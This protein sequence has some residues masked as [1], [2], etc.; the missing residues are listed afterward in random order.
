M[1]TTEAG[2]TRDISVY[3]RLIVTHYIIRKVLKIYNLLLYCLV[4]GVRQLAIDDFTGTSTATSEGEIRVQRGS[5][6]VSNEDFSRPITVEAEMKT[7]GSSECIT[8]SLFATSNYKNAD[9]SM[10][11]G[12][13]RTKWRIF[14]GDNSGEMGPVENWRKVKLELDET[15]NVN[16]YVDDDLKYTTTSEKT[17]GKLR[18][19]PGC[20]SMKI[21]NIKIGN[22]I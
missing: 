15:N 19:I 10:E 6:I 17:E 3:F 18:F 22:K 5:A 4:S 7:D 20:Q 16:Y 14:P 11:I 2:T 12:G 9:I 13:W 21:R 8:I 1:T